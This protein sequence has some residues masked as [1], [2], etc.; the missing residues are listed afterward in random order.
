MKSF[1]LPLD[2]TYTCAY[3]TEIRKFQDKQRHLVISIVY[4][5]Q[6]AQT[7]RMT[8]MGFLPADD[9]RETCL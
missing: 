6:R 3:Q 8:I 5:R 4:Y 1:F 2:F 9:E 7:G